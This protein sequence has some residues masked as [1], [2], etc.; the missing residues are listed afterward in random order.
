[1]TAIFKVKITKKKTL[2]LFY[3]CALFPPRIFP[4]HNI[5][6]DWDNWDG[7]MKP[8]LNHIANKFINNGCIRSNQGLV[9]ID[10]KFDLIF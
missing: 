6:D 4:L 3:F 7:L 10:V 2:K 5:F 8:G 9:Q 1:M